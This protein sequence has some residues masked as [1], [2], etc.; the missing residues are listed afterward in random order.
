MRLEQL[1]PVA[2]ARNRARFPGFVRRAGHPRFIGG[3]VRRLERTWPSG[4][5]ATFGPVVVLE[6]VSPELVLVD[7]ELARRERA[8]LEE[9]AQLRAL[10]DVPTLRRAVESAAEVVEPA[11]SSRHRWREIQSFSRRRILPATLLCSLLANGLFIAHLVARTDAQATS[12]GPVVPVRTVTH[13]DSATSTTQPNSVDP[14]LPNVPTTVGRLPSKRLPKPAASRAQRAANAKSSIERKIVSLILSAPAQKLPAPFVDPATG[15][16]KNNMQVI[17]NRRPRGSFL[18]VI[19][20][21]GA[22]PKEGLYVLYRKTRSGDGVFTWYGYK[23]RSQ[24]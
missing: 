9:R 17:C 14:S 22:A 11:D 15:L 12:N 7:P 5:A 2:L 1:Y 20:L 3:I 10:L 18:C 19:R 6:P 23:K 21:A 4:E 24:E 13:A 16:V 8:K